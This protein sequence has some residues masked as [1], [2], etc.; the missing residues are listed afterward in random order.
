[1]PSLLPLKPAYLGWL[2]LTLVVAAVFVRLGIWQLD[3]AEQKRQILQSY[4]TAAQIQAPSINQDTAVYSLVTGTLTLLPQQLL[5]DNQI[6]QGRAGVHVLTPALLDSQRLLLIN[7]GWLPLDST[8]TKLPET[9][10]PAIPVDIEG[11]LVPMPRVGRRLGKQASL[12]PNQWPQLITYADQEIIQQVYQTALGIPDLKILPMILQL[13]ANSDY[14]FSGR[15]WSPV[16][17]GPDKHTAYAWQWFTLALAI[18]ITWL[19]VTRIS[20]RKTE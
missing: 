2:L 15:Q 17:F 12:K 8:R 5:L 11:Q 20:I 16:N 7:R 1:M 3:R 18:L 19:V 4:A 10:V 6:L 13:D 14:G 9:P